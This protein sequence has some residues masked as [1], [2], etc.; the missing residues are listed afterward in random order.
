MVGGGNYIE[1]QN[2][3]DYCKRQQ[4]VKTITYGTSELMNA[5]KFLQQVWIYVCSYVCGEKLFPEPLSLFCSCRNSVEVHSKHF[6]AIRNFMH[7]F[8]E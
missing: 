2:L 5:R 6:S 1:Y 3:Q 4:G 7:M 8:N